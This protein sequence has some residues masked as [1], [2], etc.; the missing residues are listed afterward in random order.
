MPYTHY[1]NAI[2][3]NHKLIILCIIPISEL[4]MSHYRAMSWVQK[5]QPFFDAYTGPSK[6]ASYC[7]WTGL[8]LIV[9]I[10][11]LVVFTLKL[12]DSPNRNLFCRYSC[13]IWSN[14]ISCSDKGIYMD[15]LPYYLELFFFM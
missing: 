11:L 3:V 1:I 6:L 5:L 12:N 15:S 13:L 8:L 4:S 9:R 7:Y 10:I 14:D 2:A